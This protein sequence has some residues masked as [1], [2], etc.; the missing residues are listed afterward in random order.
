MF[1]ISLIVFIVITSTMNLF[2][3]VDWFEQRISDDYSGPTGIFT[4]DMDDDDDIDL[5]TS[6][7]GDITWWE[8]DGYQQFTRHF[9]DSTWYGARQVHAGDLDGDGDMDVVGVA[10]ESHE[11]AWYENDGQMNFTKYLLATNYRGASFARMY[12]VDDDNDMD[13]VTCGYYTTQDLSWWENTG[14]PNFTR[15]IIENS[16]YWSQ[17]D[18][19]DLDNDGDV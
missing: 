2:A 17:I 5:V 19:S 12:D 11:I 6:R 15:H 16:I 7:G 10:W 14:Y 9:I 1:K 13:I 18:V 3:Q 4:I 8:N